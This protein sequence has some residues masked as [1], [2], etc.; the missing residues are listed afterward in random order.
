MI[1]MG[2]HTNH[3]DQPEME[4]W[5][6]SFSTINTVQQMEGTNKGIIFFR[7]LFIGLI[8]GIDIQCF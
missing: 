1:L 5:P 4:V 2:D 8:F 6:E 7:A 3:H